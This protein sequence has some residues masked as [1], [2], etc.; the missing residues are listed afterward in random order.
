MAIEGVVEEVATNLEEVAEVTRRIDTRGVGF[1]LGGFVVGAS[2]G[3][4]FGRRWNREKLRLEAFKDSQAEVEKIREVYRDGSRTVVVQEKPSVEEVIEKRGYSTNAERGI[5][6]SPARPL[7]A[8]VPVQPTHVKAPP[9][10]IYEGGKDKND[11]W[12]YPHELAQRSPDEPYVIHQDE[13]SN[14]ESGYEHT[15]YTY[16]AGDDVLVDT[17][18]TPVP[19]GDLVVGQDNLKWGHG[20]D[21]IDVVFVRNDR[22]NLEIEICRSPKS[23]EE[24]ILGLDR[25]DET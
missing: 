10:V 16:Y 4:Y 22:L 21:D 7:R 23:Y 2:V 11:N 3:F 17:D 12:N 5:D 8:P 9:V 20:A 15:T 25:N 19:H 14:N 13:F 1:F 24:E 18:G 6:E